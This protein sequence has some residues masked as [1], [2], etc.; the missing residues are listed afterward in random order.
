MTSQQIDRHEMKTKSPKHPTEKRSTNPK[1]VPVKEDHRV[2][3]G[4]LR[5]EQT[6]YKLLTTA[7]AVF[8]DKGVDAPQIDD[9]IAA[10]GVA[11]GTFY[12][13]FKTTQ[14]LL[15][16]VTSNLSD[17]IHIRIA[18]VASPIQ[19]PLERMAIASLLYMYAGISVRNWGAFVVRTG[20]RKDALGKLIN[21]LVSR[22]LEH[23]KSTGQANFPSLP[24][25]LDLVVASLHQAILTVHETAAPQSHFRHVMCLIFRAIGVPSEHA[26][27]LSQ[28]ELPQLELPQWLEV[29]D[30]HE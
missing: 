12:N 23:A 1:V 27:E 7:M 21:I 17:E 25:A 26:E 2:R 15:N 10:A 20:S 3:T 8:A 29:T 4:A 19:D 24:A 22:D 9:F 30:E 11:R 16:A 18:S 14:E 28:L 6:R 13:Y 5:R